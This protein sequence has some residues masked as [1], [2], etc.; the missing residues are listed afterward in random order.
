MEET[1]PPQLYETFSPLLI[2]GNGVGTNCAFLLGFT[3]PNQNDEFGLL[4]SANWR[5]FY[6][7]V[8]VGFYVIFL[9]VMA[10]VTKHDTIKFL[11]L[12]NKRKEALLA[13]R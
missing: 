2:A 9:L 6:A 7:Y 11:I 3:L 13:I 12:K 1:C 4:N 10:F 5:I 8:P